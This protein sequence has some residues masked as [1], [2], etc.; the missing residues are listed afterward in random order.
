M[1]LFAFL[2]QKITVQCFNFG[3]ICW[4]KI[5]IVKKRKRRMKIMKSIVRIVASCKLFHLTITVAVN[6]KKN[7]NWKKYTV[8][9]NR[10]LYIKV[11]VHSLTD[12]TQPWKFYGKLGQIG[13]VPNCV[14]IEFKALTP[15]KTGFCKIL[16]P[17]NLQKG[18]CQ[19][20]AL[21]IHSKLSHEDEIAHGETRLEY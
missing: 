6:W 20:Y 21:K 15:T 14:Q 16:P 19:K 13:E 18:R 1:F 2:Y 8:S 7:Q 3:R 5:D 17:S 12:S 10:N 9:I 11:C 4:N